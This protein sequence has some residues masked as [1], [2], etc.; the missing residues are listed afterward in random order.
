MRKVILLMVGIVVTVSGMA[1]WSATGA[2]T[3]WSQGMAAGCRDTT[4]YTNAADTGIITRQC[5][6][7]KWYVKG[8]AGSYWEAVGNDTTKTRFVRL[9]PGN[10]FRQD[11]K[12][13]VSDTARAG[14]HV[15]DS[16]V[17]LVGIRTPGQLL[18]GSVGTNSVTSIGT[19]I[20]GNFQNN[21]TGRTI[22]L[23]NQGSGILINGQR[24]D[25]SSAAGELEWPVLATAKKWTM[26]SE[27]GTLALTSNVT[28]S[29][30]ALRASIN[31]KLNIS[32]TAAMLANYPLINGTRA[33]GTWNI[34]VTGNAGTATTAT[35]AT[36]VDVLNATSGV[37]GVALAGSL[38]TG[39]QRIYYNGSF[40]YNAGTGLLTFPS[41]L[42]SSS[43]TANS[44]IKSGGTSSQFLKA[45]GSVD[46]TSYTPQSRTLTINGT[47][48]DLS[49]NRSW[50]VGDVRTD[51]SYANPSWITSL[52]WSKITG[53]PTT[54]AG[55][56]ITDVPLTDG[57]GASGTWG[58]N[59][60]GNAATVTNGVY[61]TTYNTLGDA[62]YLQLTGGTLTGALSGTSAT[63][64]GDVSVRSSSNNILTVRSTNPSSSGL[65]SVYLGNNASD[66]NGT[67]ESTSDTYTPSTYF[68]PD[69]I[70]LTANR[71]GG[72]SL[73]ARNAAGVIRF[74]SG[75]DTERARFS[76]AGRLLLNTTT[77]NGT[78]LLQVNGSGR[79]STRIGVGANSETVVAI[80]ATAGG[81]TSSDFI[82]VGRNSA[83]VAKYTLDATGA[84]TFSSTVTAKTYSENYT[85]VSGTYTVASDIGT[86]FASSNTYT[87]TLPSASSF[88]GRIITIK[89]TSNG[90][91]TSITIS[92]VTLGTSENGG[93]LPCHGAATYKS[94]GTN[95]YVV[96][97][98][99]GGCN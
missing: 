7:G 29:S 58:I 30:S 72:L 55:Y 63:F 44:F 69:G 22:A 85:S 47:A 41:A 53:T 35:N 11:G 83:G 79:F 12:I 49:A 84:A 90:L 14:K 93:S 88:P 86:V 95:W 48:Q 80:A 26:P 2:K 78:D 16:V 13:W 37:A 74:F 70:S 27:S 56:G 96:S 76:T 21:S 19:S 33:T 71:A 98:H 45:D 36:N 17:A 81:T 54:R 9:Q 6:D 66:F 25:I 15:G 38:A 57:T 42:L 60:S 99:A 20:A 50:T 4:S 40:T 65:S 8:S 91:G 77:D 23:F 43:I 10:L 82:M 94:D 24:G 73:V 5:S 68:L 52:A 28:D 1:Q 34:S 3:R 39:N 51:G 31:T 92:G 89:R 64:S 67:I 46:T 87:I 32:D 62:R 61:T 18:S 75:G 97:Y 59:I